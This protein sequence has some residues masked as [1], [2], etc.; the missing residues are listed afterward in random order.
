MN[1]RKF[2]LC[3]LAVGAM[4]SVSLLQAQD[5]KKGKGGGGRGGLTVERVEEAVGTLTADQKTK[6]EAILAKSREQLQAIPQEERQAKGR[7]IMQA[8]RTEVRALLTD[9]QKKKFDEMPQG[10]RG[11]GK[12]KDK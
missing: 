2:L 7:E 4:S 3:A 11:Q 9:E 8:S 10:G 1:V 6:I 5:E 12:K